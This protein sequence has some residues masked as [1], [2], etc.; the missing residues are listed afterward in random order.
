MV[1]GALLTQNTAWKN[2]EKALA[3]LR[4]RKQLALPVIAGLPLSELEMQIKPAGFF[5]QKSRRLKNLAT[6]IIESGGLEQLARQETPALRTWF[7]R[8]QGV[9][10]ETA[11]SILLYAFKRPLFVIDA[12]TLRIGKRHG[13]LADSADYAAAQRYFTLQLEPDPDLF[14][15]FHALLVQLGKNFCRPRNPFCEKCPLQPLPETI[16]P[17]A[18]P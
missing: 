11:D 2:V 10:P 12:Y 9:G 5:R 14:N 17:Q 4:N 3:N 18:T 13:W 1:I 8:Q 6:A 7:L 16:Q 15:E